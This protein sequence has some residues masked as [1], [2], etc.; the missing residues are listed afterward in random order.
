MA[1][2]Y[3]FRLKEQEQARRV[4]VCVMRTAKEVDITGVR[5][6]TWMR[7]LDVCS[8]RLFHIGMSVSPEKRG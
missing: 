2:F 8:C 5:M 1:A 3:G 6:L 4:D 7:W